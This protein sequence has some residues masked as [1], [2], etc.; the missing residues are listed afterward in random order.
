ML[1]KGSAIK[2]HITLSYF[3]F[4]LILK[5][6]PLVRCSSAQESGGY[7]SQTLLKIMVATLEITFVNLIVKAIRL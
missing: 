3:F 7:F 6:G 2:Q 5:N 1:L 4:R